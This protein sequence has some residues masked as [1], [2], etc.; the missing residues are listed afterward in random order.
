M[1]SNYNDSLY[2]G[3]RNTTWL[4]GPKDKLVHGIKI[5]YMVSMVIDALITRTINNILGRHNY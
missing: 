3:H 1:V 4:R 2:C 5:S